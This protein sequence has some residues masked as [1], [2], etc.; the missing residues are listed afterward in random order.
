MKKIVLDTNCLLMSLPKISPYRN[1]WES[2]LLCDFALC[3]S[4]D[5]IEEYYE[6]ISNK[7]SQEVANNVISTILNADNTLF[8]TPYYHFGLIT[9]DPDDNKFVDCCIAANATYIVTNDR[10]FDVVKTIAFPQLC[11]LN[12]LDFSHKLK[13]SL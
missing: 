13:Y 9:K 8:V 10:H 7:T 4:T 11:V 1:I 2:F 3:V 6:I 5:I 12:I